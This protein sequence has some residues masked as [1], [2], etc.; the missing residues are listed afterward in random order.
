MKD[1]VVYVEVR[2][3]MDNRTDGV[4]GVIAKLG[5]KV[6]DRLTKYALIDQFSI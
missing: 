5:A 2:S 3:D 6:N 1:V 4:K